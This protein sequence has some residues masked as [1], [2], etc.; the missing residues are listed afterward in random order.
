MGTLKDELT[1]W[2][3][4]QRDHYLCVTDPEIRDLSYVEPARSSGYLKKPNRDAERALMLRLL[5]QRPSWLTSELRKVAEMERAAFFALLQDMQRRGWLTR[6][7]G[8][9][10]LKRSGEHD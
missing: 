8:V 1:V 7:P 9:V 5:G 3:C 10:A 6:S 2:W 4:G